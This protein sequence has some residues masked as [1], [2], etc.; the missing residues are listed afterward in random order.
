[1]KTKW[2]AFLLV[3]VMVAS[4][5]PMA[6]AKCEFTDNC[7][8]KNY[9]DVSVKSWYH[10]YVD[11]VVGAG[12]M[13]GMEKDAFV[14]EYKLNRA[15]A[16]TILWRLL[17]Q[18]PAKA[19]S[20]FKDVPQKAWYAGAVAFMQESSLMNGMEKDVFDPLG[21]MTREQFVTVLYRLDAQS[22]AY[23]KPDA[24]LSVF[25]DASTIASWAKKAMIWA[26]SEKIIQGDDL[27]NINPKNSVK[28]SEAA[29]L[30]VRLFDRN[31]VLPDNI[32]KTEAQLKAAIAEGGTIVVDKDIEIT[33][34]DIITFAKDTTLYL[35]G[36]VLANNH[37]SRPFQVA[38]NTKLTIYAKDKTVQ[39]GN[40]GL[41]NIPEGDGVEIK[42]FGGNFVGKTDFGSFIKPRGEGKMSVE[43][44]DVTLTDASDN[45]GFVMD[46]TSH[47]G[48]LEFKA[49][50][51][52]FSA[53]NGV[54][55][56]ADIFLSN[57]KMNM[58]HTGV[59]VYKNGVINNCTFITE[60]GGTDKENAESPSA[61]VIAYSNGRVVVTNS[62]FDC[63]ADALAVYTSGGDIVAVNCEFKNGTFS[64]YHPRN[65]YPDAE[66]SIT[67]DG[68]IPS[69]LKQPNCQDKTPCDDCK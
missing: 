63:A 4:M 32:V 18:Q 25:K 60:N 33:E 30:I 37:D 24:D 62:T 13:T 1:M 53:Y 43:L 55:G 38:K 15:M 23:S 11:Q 64:E 8:T 14:P 51:S 28:R 61:A 39:M 45:G 54:V 7:P 2:F 57:V 9:T 19:P 31:I 36:D 52:E 29:A 46:A 50:D 40:F 49:Y 20:T 10:E 67:I 17:G 41:I 58:V 68:K 5:V 16:A 56:A 27:G 21:Q 59:H 65:H 42:I 35:Y 69:T 6:S 26:V 47:S 34:N 48:D 12:I 3:L 66:F 44:H 22:G